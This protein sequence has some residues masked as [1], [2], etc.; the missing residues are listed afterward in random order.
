MIRGGAAMPIQDWTRVDAGL[1]QDFRSSWIVEIS[2]A[3]NGSVLGAGHYALL[4]P[5]AVT[6]AEIV[7]PPGTVPFR[8]PWQDVPEGDEMEYYRCRK[9]HI[10][11]RRESDD[12]A[13]AVLDIPS[14]GDKA[15]PASVRAIAKRLAGLWRRGV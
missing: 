12:A 8:E 7:A 11:V 6:V 4:A 15:S 5:A 9:S 3:L 13:V 2:R 10:V 14:A 1:F